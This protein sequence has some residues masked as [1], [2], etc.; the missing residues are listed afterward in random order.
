MCFSMPP[1]TSSGTTFENLEE[2]VPFKFDRFLDEGAPG[3]EEN[4]AHGIFWH[5]LF[6]HSNWN[7]SLVGYA[8]QLSVQPDVTAMGITAEELKN[9]FSDPEIRRMDYVKRTIMIRM[10][11]DLL[12]S[13]PIEKT[14]PYLL[15]EYFERA[16]LYLQSEQGEDDC[17]LLDEKVKPGFCSIDTDALTLS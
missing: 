14:D 11:K 7:L 2:V 12:G 6:E 1:T 17:F 3:Q 5:K 10:I 16:S 13:T 8:A 15:M 4:E 9:Y